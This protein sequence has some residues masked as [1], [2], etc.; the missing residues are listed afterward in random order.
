MDNH[1]SR[2]VHQIVEAGAFEGLEI[3][4][5]INQESTEGKAD[6]VEAVLF[7]DDERSLQNTL[8]EDMENQ[9]TARESHVDKHA[10]VIEPAAFEAKVSIL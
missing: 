5:Q 3:P 8:R 9:R 4:D 2:K 1:H 7:I 10:K 6:G